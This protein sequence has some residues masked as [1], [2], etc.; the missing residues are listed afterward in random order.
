MLSARS[1]RAN[2]RRNTGSGDFDVGVLIGQTQAAERQASAGARDGVKGKRKDLGA[3]APLH[4]LVRRLSPAWSRT[5]LDETE[6]APA[7]A[8]TAEAPYLRDHPNRPDA[9]PII[10]ETAVRIGKA[11]I[12]R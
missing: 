10:P 4:A 6:R 12:D 7:D 9:S 2:L 3:R 1:N 8:T 11:L 5:A